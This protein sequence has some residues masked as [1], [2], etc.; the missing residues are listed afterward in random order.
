MDIDKIKSID[1]VDFMLKNGYKQGKGRSGKW[2]S[3][4]SPFGSESNASFKCDVSDNRW[5]DYSAGITR[6]HSIIDLVMMLPPYPSFKE[7]CDVLLSDTDLEARHFEPKKKMNGTKVHSESKPF[8]KDLISML[9]DIRCIDHALVMKYCVEIVISFPM[10]ANP[11]QTFRVIGMKNDLGGV[12]Y[13]G[14]ESW[15][16]LHKPEIIYDNKG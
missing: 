16:K 11:E 7:A 4:Y 14:L 6:K 15:L 2:R 10:G 8:S 13:R 12:D 5:V 9:T 3:F 1:I